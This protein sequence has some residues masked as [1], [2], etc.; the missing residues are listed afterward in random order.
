[1]DKAYD[2]TSLLFTLEHS[3]K[4][5]LGAEIA[6]LTQELHNSMF[7]QQGITD[8]PRM[9]GQVADSWVEPRTKGKIYREGV[10]KM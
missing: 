9:R 1:M 8:I 5:S 7:D 10:T 2:F 4:K 6:H 3:R